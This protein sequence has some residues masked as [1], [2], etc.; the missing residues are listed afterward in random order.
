MSKVGEVMETKLTIFTPTYNRAYILP[1]LYKSLLNQSN[2]KFIWLVVDDGSTDETEMLVKEWIEEAKL[3]IQYI[4]QENQGKHIAH[5][6]AVENCQTELF[7]C[8]DSDDYLLGHA[9]EMILEEYNFIK[10]KEVSGI[11]SI[12]IKENMSPIGTEMPT[13][14]NYSSLTDLY[15]KYHL[16]GDTALVFKTKILQEFKFPQIKGEKFIGEEYVYC[17]IDEFFKLYL[18][19]N[20]YYVCAYLDDGYTTNMFNLISKNPKGYMKLKIMALKK[21]KGFLAKIKNAICYVSVWF[22][23]RNCYMHNNIYIYLNIIPGYFLYLK[24]YKK[25]VLNRRDSK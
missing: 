19:Q 10:S 24:R 11:V 2:K 16:K 12:R 21:S 13:K 8:V 22:I 20:R 6:T 7:F 4:K 3:C 14:I 23:D 9:V 1:K 5:N 15:Q 25:F 17:Q 18:S